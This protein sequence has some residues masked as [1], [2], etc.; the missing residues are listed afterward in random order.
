MAATPD[1]ILCSL[2]RI[3]G[4]LVEIR[5]SS[6]CVEIRQRLKNLWAAFAAARVCLLRTR[7]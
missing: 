5:K 4:K 6:E 2:R 1:E 7:L 3:E